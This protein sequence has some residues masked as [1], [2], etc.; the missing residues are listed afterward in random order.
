MS[1]SRLTPFRVT[2]H[3]EPI[4]DLLPSQTVNS[5]VSY[6]ALIPGMVAEIE[7]RDSSRF[8][9]YTWAEWRKLSYDERVTGVAY[10]RLSR[11]IEMHK[12]DAVATE[13]RHRSRH[14]HK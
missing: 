11:V 1:A 4:L 6:N 13:L 8:N 3:G 14:P 7:E 5:G 10:Y 2:R 9:G 12:E